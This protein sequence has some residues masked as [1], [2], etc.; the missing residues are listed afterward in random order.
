MAVFEPGLVRAVLSRAVTG[1]GKWEYS[2]SALE[3]ARGS[4][5][6][7]LRLRDLPTISL[8]VVFG[9]WDP[10][11]ADALLGGRSM[12]IFDLTNVDELAALLVYVQTV[13]M[14]GFHK[15]VDA[16]VREFRAELD[17]L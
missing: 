17:A 6:W 3:A 7:R 2:C 10:V 4:G 5:I 11:R 12:Q 14:A 16:E 15:E 1:S 13:D 9:G 8:E